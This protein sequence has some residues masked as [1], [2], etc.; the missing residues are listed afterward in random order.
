MGILDKTL[1]TA[2]MA[3]R[4]VG[5][6]AAP[7]RGGGG[8][9]DIGDADLANKVR[10]ELF[11]GLTGVDK[12]AIDVNVVDG[13]VYLRGTAKNP[14]QIKT[15]EGRAH[16]IPEV[17]EV[18][19]LLHLPK[20]PAPTRTDTPASQRKTRRTTAE[21]PRR[22]PRRVNADKTARSGETPP[23]ELAAQRAGRPAA[24]LGS[25]DDA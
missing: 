11:R 4:L 22:E 14:Q 5:R 8:P 19:N 9:K 2:G 15:L 13:A 1:G 12:G 6:L 25:R 3:L 10:T 20:T 18:H 21:R 17:T 16:A 24:P 23:D 7:L